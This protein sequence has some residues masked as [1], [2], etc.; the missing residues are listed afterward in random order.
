MKPKPGLYIV[1]T[2][3]G[4]MLDITYRAIETMRGSDYIFC[5][6]TRVTKKLLEKHQIKAKLSIYNDHSDN[7]VRNYIKKLIDEGY[8][9]SLVSDAGTP[10]IS[11]PGYKLVREMQIEG[12]FIDIAPGVSSPIAAIT[13]SGMPSDRFIFNGFLPRTVESKAKIFE[14]LECLNAT[15]IFFETANRLISSLE[16]ALSVLGDREAVV[17]REITKL[18]QTVKRDKISRLISFFNE[19]ILKGEIVLLISGEAIAPN[20]QSLEEEIKELLARKLSTKDTVKILYKKYPTHNKTAI[21]NAVKNN[22]INYAT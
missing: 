13:L 22:K 16:V 18:Y 8:V 6:D 1:S 7:E 19:N 9:V 2:P 10:L 14:D 21:Y 11:D 5:E 4:N 15:L 20:I 17:A 3:I 12:Y